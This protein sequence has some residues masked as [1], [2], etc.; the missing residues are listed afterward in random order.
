[1]FKGFTNIPTTDDSRNIKC[2][3]WH[4]RPSVPLAS[5]TT[6]TC[7]QVA[8]TAQMVGAVLCG[9]AWL[10]QVHTQCIYV[11]FKFYLVYH[12]YF[13]SNNHIKVVP[14]TFLQVLHLIRPNIVAIHHST[15]SWNVFCISWIL[16]Y[17]KLVNTPG[18]KQCQFELLLVSLL[19]HF[20]TLKI[21]EAMVVLWSFQKYLFLIYLV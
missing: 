18:G 3:K 11:Q 13:H 9:L 17:L 21:F 12:C 20:V 7:V 2:V 19:S 15:N 8:H 1:M 5:L 10:R 14:S 6:P 4:F 16:Y